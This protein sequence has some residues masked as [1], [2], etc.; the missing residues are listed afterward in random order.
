MRRNPIIPKLTTHLLDDPDSAPLLFTWHD[1]TFKHHPNAAAVWV[2]KSA[3]FKVRI[4]GQ[5]FLHAEARRWTAVIELKGHTTGSGWSNRSP[6][7]ALATLRARLSRI[8][9]LGAEANHALL[10][11]G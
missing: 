3:R 10:R 5:Q 11:I 9:K 2:A 1:L 6:T 8:I 4:V 7:A